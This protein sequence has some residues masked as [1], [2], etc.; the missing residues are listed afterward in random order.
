M[1]ERDIFLCIAT[2]TSAVRGFVS[3]GFIIADENRSWPLL[4]DSGIVMMLLTVVLVC[5]A[6]LSRILLAPRPVAGALSVIACV[7]ATLYS[8]HT[9]LPMITI[10]AI[11]VLCEYV[12]IPILIAAA[13]ASCATGLFTHMADGPFV[14]ASA[15]IGAGTVYILALIRKKHEA[16]GD[17][18]KSGER[19]EELRERIGSRDRLANSI[20]HISRL[21]ER[22]RLAARIHDEIGHGMSGSILLLEGADAIMDSDPEA[23]RATMRRVAGNLR[24]STD[25]IRAVLREERSAASEVNLA[26]VKA[27]LTSFEAAHPNIRT[28][29]ITDGDQESV[30]GQIWTCVMD[31]MTEAMTNTLKH[32]DATSF[33]VSVTNSNKLLRV[34]FADNGAAADTAGGAARRFTD[35]TEDARKGIGMQNMEERCAFA[36]GRCFFRQNNDGFRVIMTFPLKA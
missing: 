36:Y 8:P 7:I 5:A 33:K 20:A 12:G 34:E 26:R 22:N 21:E 31:N 10:S 11:S 2:L 24:G 14:V 1:K 17:A 19:I 4:S 9:A 30:A 16:R 32:S 15:L 3:G 18:D 25:T 27:E 29:L 35:F 6:L 28:E 13:A 23:A